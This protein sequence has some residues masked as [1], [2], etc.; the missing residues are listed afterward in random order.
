MNFIDS[1]C[2]SEHGR[3]ISDTFIQIL[4]RIGEIVG[5]TE[6]LFFLKGK[7]KI[8]KKVNFKY[9]NLK[10]EYYNQEK[11]NPFSIQTTSKY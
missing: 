2:K 8:Y 10:K 4:N 6:T 1:I 9:V 3:K 5:R 11:A 7:K